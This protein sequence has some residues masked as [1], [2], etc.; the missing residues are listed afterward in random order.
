MKKRVASTDVGERTFRNGVSAERTNIP[1]KQ[2]DIVVDLPRQQSW[3]RSSSMF[4][5]SLMQSKVPCSKKSKTIALNYAVRLLNIP[6]LTLFG[7][8]RY[9]NTNKHPLRIWKWAQMCWCNHLFKFNE[10]LPEVIICKGSKD[11]VPGFD[12]ELKLHLS[13]LMVVSCAGLG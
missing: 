7:L 5:K 12:D 6:G 11:S 13:R 1:D 9:S 4:K 8:F 3:V 10:S 2:N